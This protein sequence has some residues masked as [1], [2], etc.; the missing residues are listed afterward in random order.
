MNHS[1]IHEHAVHL[2][3][4]DIRQRYNGRAGKDYIAGEFFREKILR[5]GHYRKSIFNKARGDILDVACGTGENFAHYNKRGDSYTAIELSPFMLEGAKKRADKL[6]MTVALHVMDAQT[7]DFPDKSFDTVLSA[8]STC[9]FPDPIA[10]L[11]EMQRVCKADGRILLFEHGRSTWGLIA[12]W[13][14]STASYMYETAGCRA[15][16]NPL[17][18]V[19]AAGLHVI[20]ARTGLFGIFHMIEISPR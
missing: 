20:S 8:L 1:H 2:D 18:L 7:L 4:E 12:R 11:R 17:E 6:G 14:D 15:T 5:A 10:A 3:S 9:T 16:Q 13:Q 19:Q